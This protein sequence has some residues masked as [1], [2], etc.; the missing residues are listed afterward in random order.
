MFVLYNRLQAENIDPKRV[1]Q[2]RQE[3][4]VAKQAQID[5]LNRQFWVEKEQVRENKYDLQVGLKDLGFAV[6]QDRAGG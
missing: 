4:P 6:D 3:L 5:Q 2:W 1:E